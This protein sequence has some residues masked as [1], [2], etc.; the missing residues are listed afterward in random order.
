MLVKPFGPDWLLKEVHRWERAVMIIH[1]AGLAAIAFEGLTIHDYTAGQ[2]LSSSVALIEVP[3]GAH[4][5]MAYSTRSDKYYY[6]MSGRISFTIGGV[7]ED[8]ETEDV[9][10][11]RRGERFSYENGRS[12]TAQ[13]LLVHTPSFDAAAEMFCEQD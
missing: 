5:G 9:C 6:V 3:P 13:I 7:R 2:E 10:I 1:R 12:E 4:H 11:I 8:G